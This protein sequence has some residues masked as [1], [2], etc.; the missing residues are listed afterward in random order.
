M[1]P[2]SAGS[3]VL[4]CLPGVRAPRVQCICSSLAGGVEH[5]A[6]PQGLGMSQGT[7]TQTWLFHCPMGVP[8]LEQGREEAKETGSLVTGSCQC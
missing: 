8:Q 7:L 2:I 3:R 4:L 1:C 5:H 6:A